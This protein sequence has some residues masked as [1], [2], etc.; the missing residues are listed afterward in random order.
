MA[1]QSIKLGYFHL[2]VCYLLHWLYSG[3]MYRGDIYCI[4]VS[5]GM[6]LYELHALTSNRYISI[7]YQ[8]RIPISELSH[9]CLSFA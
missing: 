6:F 2:A 7:G 3:V 5:E 8:P 1:N 9:Y 4:T